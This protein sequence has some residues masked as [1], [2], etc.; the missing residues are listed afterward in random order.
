MP[1]KIDIRNNDFDFYGNG[2]SGVATKNTTTNIDFKIDKDDLYC[3]GG[4]IIVKDAEHGDYI[5]IQILDIDNILGYGANTVLQT[6][7]KKWY[8]DYRGKNTLEV[9]YAGYIYK[10]LYLRL[11]YTSVG[12]TYDVKVAVN[13]SFH[14]EKT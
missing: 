5:E 14:I 7:L 6:Y 9:P 11:K 8:I 10:N 13:Y 2:T 4:E 3:S 1:G 12:T